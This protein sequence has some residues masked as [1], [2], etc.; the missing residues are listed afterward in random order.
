MG[1]D[2]EL[3]RERNVGWQAAEAQSRAA[4]AATARLRAG[5]RRVRQRSGAEVRQEFSRAFSML[6]ELPD[7][8]DF[9]P[10]FLV[11][12]QADFF[13]RSGG[14]RD[15]KKKNVRRVVKEGRWRSGTS[16]KSVKGLEVMANS[17]RT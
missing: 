11:L 16:G 12:L 13:F 9:K 6:Q 14:V 8:P 7:L 17:C 4:R 1:R 5:L 10:G 3:F 2:P 15:R